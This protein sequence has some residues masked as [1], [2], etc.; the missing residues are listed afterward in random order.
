VPP[1]AQGN[2]PSD[3]TEISTTM[4][5]SNFSSFISWLAQVFIIQT[6][7]WLTVLEI[8]LMTRNWHKKRKIL[9]SQS[10]IN[11]KH[12]SH[13]IWHMTKTERVNTV[14]KHS[15]YITCRSWTPFP[16]KKKLVGKMKKLEHLPNSNIKNSKLLIL[17]IVLLC[18]MLTWG[19]VEWWD[20]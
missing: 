3:Q 4:S 8:A 16:A 20:I 18:Q 13:K 19:K 6:K 9:P 14:Q 1:Q 10:C 12:Q 17:I 7:S 2:R 11:S 15:N 5:Q